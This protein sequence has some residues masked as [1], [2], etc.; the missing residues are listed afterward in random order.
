MGMRIGQYGW[1]PERMWG[2]VAIA[3]AL[4]Y[5]LIG[6]WSIWRG[7]RDFDD[8]LR[9]LQVKLSIG[10]CALMVL[11]ALPIID[12]GAISSRSQVARLATGKVEPAKLDWAAL[13]FDFGPSGRR[14]LAEMARTGPSGWR[15]L[16]ADAL[17]AEE[18]WGLAEATRTAT[19]AD[20]IKGRIR[21]LT[22]GL[23]VTPDVLRAIAAR[24]SC[25][26]EAQ[27]ALLR[28]DDQKMVLVAK[29]G[30]GGHVAATV[31]DPS[32]PESLDIVR[33]APAPPK[34]EDLGKVR[35]EVRDVPRKQV[36]VDGQ[37]VGED[38]E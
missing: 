31:I 25:P 18:R 21:I 28:V 35:I 34:V 22:P 26:E 11:L 12:F 24:R 38:F 1:T 16:A 14:Q 29:Y 30:A 13:A 33:P 2:A 3:I 10:V 7:R 8:V 6:W 36:F 5:G 32:K 27:C 20:D 15:Q 9:S 19:E 4:A 17:K 23:Q 37:P